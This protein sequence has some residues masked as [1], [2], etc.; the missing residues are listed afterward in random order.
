MAG[1]VACLF[2]ILAF[3]DAQARAIAFVVILFG[4]IILI[5]V[6]AL[7]TPRDRSVKKVRRWWMFWRRRVAKKGFDS[8]YWKR[9][10]GQQKH[11][12]FGHRQ[13]TQ[14][15]AAKSSTFVATPRKPTEP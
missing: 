11:V 1:F 5:P 2:V 9:K 13:V 12:P 14:P 7:R 4:V 6:A 15:A 10:R 8:P 3:S